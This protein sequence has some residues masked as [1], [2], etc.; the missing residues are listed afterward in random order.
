VLISYTSWGGG[1]SERRVDPYGLV[2]H[3]GRWYVTGADSLRG[4]VRTFRL[5]RIAA[6]TLVPGSFEVPDDFDPI[7]RVV[8]GLAEVP[9]PHEVSVLLHTTVEDVRAKLPASVATLTETP[10]G[11]RLLLRAN[12]LEWAAAVLAWLGCTFE[13]EY[14]DEL[15]AEVRKLA[16]R[17]SACAG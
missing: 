10:D 17:L 14:P 6:A 2:F 4:E 13:I 9:Y 11:V 3:S 1:A 7:A 5:D 16:D 15:R 12:R 8:T